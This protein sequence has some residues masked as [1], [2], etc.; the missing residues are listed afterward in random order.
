MENF[1]G[2]VRANEGGVGSEIGVGLTAY[3][4]RGPPTTWSPCFSL[5]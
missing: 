2:A 3:G 1:P 4:E 5:P